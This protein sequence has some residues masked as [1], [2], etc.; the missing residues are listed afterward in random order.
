MGVVLYFT[1][2]T[3]VCTQNDR[4]GHGLYKPINTV[5]KISIS[6]PTGSTLLDAS[7]G[8]RNVGSSRSEEIPSTGTH[9][10]DWL[11]TGTFEKELSLSRIINQRSRLSRLYGVS[12]LIWYSAPLPRNSLS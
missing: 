4:F 10:S 3:L 5:L 9:R 11:R 1:P 6:S 2:K 8:S 7:T 12:R